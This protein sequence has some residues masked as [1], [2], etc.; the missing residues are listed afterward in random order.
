LFFKNFISEYSE[1]MVFNIL[2]AASVVI[3]SD[4]N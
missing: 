2:L 3:F 1:Y 4:L